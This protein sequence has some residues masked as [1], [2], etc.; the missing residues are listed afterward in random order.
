MILTVHSKN[1]TFSSWF[2]QKKYYKMD[3]TDGMIFVILPEMSRK[4]IVW[5]SE[6]SVRFIF[7]GEEVVR[8]PLS[9]CIRIINIT[10]NIKVW[11]EYLF[12]SH[13]WRVGGHSFFEFSP[14]SFLERKE[15][16][17]RIGGHSGGF[18]LAPFQR[19]NFTSSVSTINFSEPVK[20]T[21]S[22]SQIMRESLD[23]SQPKIQKYLY[24][25][26]LR[27]VKSVIKQF[28]PVSVFNPA[29]FGDVS[30][31]IHNSNMAI[32]PKSIF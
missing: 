20:P 10:Y 5:R 27:M 13:F 15:A 12:Q 6:S 28:S 17:E 11:R 4:V 16:K 14:I 29:H 23:H 30:F 2:L 21:F 22:P 7:E 24:F 25:L 9:F 32:P 18:P 31:S 19:W 1:A 3:L 26:R 8:L